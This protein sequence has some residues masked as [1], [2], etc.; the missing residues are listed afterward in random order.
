MSLRVAQDLIALGRGIGPEV[1]LEF[2]KK[3][4]LACDETYGGDWNCLIGSDYVGWLH[5]RNYLFYQIRD[6]ANTTDLVIY[7]TGDLR[8]NINDQTVGNSTAE[9]VLGGIAKVVA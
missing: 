5:Y 7:N 9:I 3:F 8:V 1:S 4:A 6:G 2:C